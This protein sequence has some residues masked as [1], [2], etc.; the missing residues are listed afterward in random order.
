MVSV[1]SCSILAFGIVSLYFPKAAGVILALANLLSISVSV[2]IVCIEA[3][4]SLKVGC[5]QRRVAFL[6]A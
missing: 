3:I 2:S 5:L 6:R 4:Y 1:V